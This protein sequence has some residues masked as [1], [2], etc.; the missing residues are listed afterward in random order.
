MPYY[1][2]PNL[3]PNK[4]QN[5]D[6]QVAGGGQVFGGSSQPTPSSGGSA[7]G[8]TKTDRFQNLND[9]LTANQGQGFGE[10]FAGNL[11]GEVDKA[12]QQQQE[13]ESLVKSQ[14][15]SGATQYDQPFVQGAIDNATDFASDSGNLDKFKAQRDAEYKGPNSYADSADAYN[16]AYGAT[17]KAQDYTSAAQS[18]GGRF[19]LLD[20]Y[21]GRPEYKQGE[22]ALDNLLVSNDSKAQEGISQAKKNADVS[23]QNFDTQ[24]K[25]VSDYAASRRGETEAT[26]KSTRDA[27][28]L[29]STGAVV[30]DQSG[31]PTG[32]AIGSLYGSL[33]QKT[34]AAQSQY[35]T[36]V[37]NIQNAVTSG[38]Y[39]KLS[40]QEVSMLGASPRAAANYGVDQSKYL[41]FT[42][43]D[44][45]NLSSTTSP[46][47]AARLNALMQLA[48]QNQSYIDT[49]KAGTAPTDYV[50]YDQGG[51]DRDVGTAKNAYDTESQRIRNDL[52]QYTQ[53]GM[54][55]NP[56]QVESLGQFA[57]GRVVNQEVL[58]AW[59]NANYQQKA[60][61]LLA[62]QAKYGV[63][64]DPGM[65]V[66]PNVRTAF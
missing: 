62:L 21:F 61:E 25:D 6:P 56:Q 27:L 45:F 37:K 46:E 18:E 65:T 20:N 9:Y 66:K 24:T 4:D 55:T 52:S 34:Q 17:Q 50:N 33:N 59:K 28:G 19:A 39:S 2:D 42:P 31:N 7:N 41:S 30:A 26:R 48:G 36:S 60:K 3:D 12:G 44:D 63:K 13:S 53:P 10:K 5:A 51:F 16:K 23:K 22:K 29:D 1:Y 47:E 43:K 57:N 64:S 11:Q 15:D 8:P 54:P 58:D 38:D 40:Q 32:G 49:T 35:D 14:A